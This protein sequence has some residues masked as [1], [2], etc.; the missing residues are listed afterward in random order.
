M[1]IPSFVIRVLALTILLGIFFVLGAQL[2]GVEQAS[3]PLAA[4]QTPTAPPAGFLAPFLFFCF[5]V[6]TVMAYLIMRSTWSG[7]P[8]MGLLGFVM[9]SVMTVATQVESLFFLQSKMPLALIE[10]LFVHGAITTALFVPC[11]VILMG[12]LRSPGQVPTTTFAAVPAPVWAGRV[13]FTIVLFIFLYMFFGYFVAWR[14]PD[15]RQFY[16][17]HEFSGFFDALQY[18]WHTAPTIYALQVFRSLLFF[19]CVLWLIRSLKVP[20][21]EATLA[22]SAFLSVWTVIL[23]LPNPIMPPSVARSHFW[24]TFFCFL[25]FGAILGWMLSPRKQPAALHKTAS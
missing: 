17:G 10:R 12:R 25:I 11:A 6:S 19:A 21:W 9:Y 14:N 23:L 20:R 18:N 13:A 7:L 8:L 24:E 4:T 3:R 15:L 2:A 16:G 22:T 5:C 1:K